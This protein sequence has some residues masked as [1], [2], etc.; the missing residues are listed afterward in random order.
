M[1][2]RYVPGMRV[3]NLMALPAQADEVIKL[4]VTALLNGFDVMA[5]HDVIRVMRFCFPCL[6]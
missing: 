2:P 4:I 1:F 5:V 3:L 6:L